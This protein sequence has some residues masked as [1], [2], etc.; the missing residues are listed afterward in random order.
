[1]SSIA[2]STT[3]SSLP[4][5]SQETG[6]SPFSVPQTQRRTP[7]QLQPP[8]QEL[9]EEQRDTVREGIAGVAGYRSTQAQIEAY[10][11]GAQQA[12]NTSSA[13]EDTAAYI[14]NYNNFAADLRRSDAINTYVDNGGDFSRVGE[15]ASTLPINQIDASQRDSVRHVGLASEGELP[16]AAETEQFSL[17]QTTRAIESYNLIAQS[18]KDAQNHATYLQNSVAGFNTVGHGLVHSG[19]ESA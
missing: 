6:T 18:S 10:A 16:T 8:E 7:E 4:V 5:Q 15:R 1:M 17:L 19:F 9:S 14:E 12:N 2:N 3:I 11:A 13:Y